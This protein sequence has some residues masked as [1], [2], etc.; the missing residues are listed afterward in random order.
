M[1]EDGG[2]VCIGGDHIAPIL[3]LAPGLSWVF[4]VEPILS[5]LVFPP[6]L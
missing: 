6:G 1:T 4:L 2:L 5:R 3:H